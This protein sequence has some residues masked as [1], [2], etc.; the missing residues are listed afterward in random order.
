MVR[1]GTALLLGVDPRVPRN[2]LTWPLEVHIISIRITSR[3][4]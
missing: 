2:A 1:P 3:K 4:S